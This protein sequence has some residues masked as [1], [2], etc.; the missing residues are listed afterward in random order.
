MISGKVILAERTRS[1]AGNAEQDEKS[2][3]VG[4]EIP[5]DERQER[6]AD[7]DGAEVPLGEDK[8]VG[9]ERRDMISTATSKKIKADAPQGT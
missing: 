9:L 8:A 1:I 7:R 2:S 5:D 3:P 6:Q 4:D